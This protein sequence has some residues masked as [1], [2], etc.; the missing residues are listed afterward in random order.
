MAK[1]AKRRALSIR[2]PFAELIMRGKKDIEY[3]SRQT[4]IRER[5]FVYACKAQSRGGLPGARP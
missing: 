2:Q 4:H 5:V 1:V 3:R